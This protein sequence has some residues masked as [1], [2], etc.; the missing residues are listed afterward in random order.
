MGAFAPFL[1]EE[2]MKVLYKLLPSASLMLSFGTFSVCG[3]GQ[4]P[5]CIG[6]SASM[7]GLLAYISTKKLV[8]GKEAWNGKK[9]EGGIS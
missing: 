2:D 8:V 4:C 6:A 1:K 3:C 5:A 9:Q 7:V